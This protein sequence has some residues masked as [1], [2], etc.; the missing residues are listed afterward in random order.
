MKVKLNKMMSLFLTLAMLI[1]MLTVGAMVVFA[2]EPPTAA[3][4]TTTESHDTIEVVPGVVSET[5]VPEVPVV[6]T[7]P[8]TEKP[9][10]AS[11]TE[12]PAV[13]I[14]N[15]EPL[16]SEESAEPEMTVVEDPVSSTVT[17][18]WGET[19]TYTW[20]PESKTLTI[21]GIDIGSE[22][23]GGYISD[24]KNVAKVVNIRG[25]ILNFESYAM[26]TLKVEGTVDWN[27]F[28]NCS[29]LKE[30][31]VEDNSELGKNAFQGCSNLTKVTFNGPNCMVSL[32]GFPSA[33]SVT[34]YGPDDCDLKFIFEQ[35]GYTY[36]VMGDNNPCLNGEHS[37]VVVRNEE[38]TCTEAGYYEAY[39]ER[40]NAPSPA[41]GVVDPLGHNYE[42][43]THICSRCGAV[44]P[45]YGGSED[46]ANPF[47]DVNPNK[48]YYNAI[49]WALG[50]GVTSGTSKTTFSPN[51]TCTRA[52]I[53]TFLWRAAGSPNPSISECPFVDVESGKFYEKAVLWALENGITAGTAPD[54][55]SPKQECTRAQIVTFIW[56]Y[57]GS[58]IEGDASV[59]EDLKPGAYYINAVAWAVAN[60]MTAGTAPGKFSP[61]KECT[62]AEAVTFI[63]RN[64]GN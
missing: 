15:E 30:V 47:D 48:W 57:E 20:D 8:D 4:E 29:N 61:N 50:H 35:S 58:K 16:E 49:I 11:A 32:T 44:D 24:Y 54:K 45:N 14:G 7:E 34:I 2:E 56:R 63:Y 19:A 36:I 17:G 5:E 25:F 42:E 28:E 39:C 3:I 13:V 51:K 43:E 40:C 59:F 46:P 22:I 23:D 10:E 41:N 38:P 1:S 52:E 26:E 31:V 27:A 12:V 55:F 62:R 33:E 60:H 9:S 21:E 6:T 18:N 64:F 37:Y 53:V